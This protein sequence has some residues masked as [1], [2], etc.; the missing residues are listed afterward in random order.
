MRNE[1]RPEKV[2]MMK[3]LATKKAKK[4]EKKQD[5]KEEKEDK[6]EK[7]VQDCLE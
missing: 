4:G 1:H 2:D 5:K 7:A 6:E 3:F